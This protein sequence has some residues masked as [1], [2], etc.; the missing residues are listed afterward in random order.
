MKKFVALLVVFTL[1]FIPLIQ[2]TYASD[3]DVLEQLKNVNANTKIK[4]DER[5]NNIED[6]MSYEDF[7]DN[8]LSA[9]GIVAT[10]LKILTDLPGFF[11]TALTT[12]FCFLPSIPTIIYGIGE[13]FQISYFDSS[14][15]GYAG[16]LSGVVSSIY[17]GFRN[18]AMVIYV[19]LIAYL[20]IRMLLAS[21]GKQKAMYKTLIKY[22]FIGLLLLGA[23]HFIM[24]YVIWFSNIITN[25]FFNIAAPYF[26]HIT[27]GISNAVLYYLGLTLEGI[28]DSTQAD[29]N[30]IIGGG[31][32]GAAELT[33]Y[34]IT[35]PTG[36]IFGG[37][38]EGVVG[39]SSFVVALLPAIFKLIAALAY[40]GVLLAVA[41]TYLKRLFM[42]TL[43]IILYPFVSMSYVFDKIGDRKAQTLERWFREFATNVFI[44]PIHAIILTFLLFFMHVLDLQNIYIIGPLFGVIMLMLLFKGEEL[45]KNLFQ[46]SDGMGGVSFSKSGAGMLGTMAAVGGGIRAIGGLRQGISARNALDTFEKEKGLKFEERNGKIRKLTNNERLAKAQKG[47]YLTEY[48]RLRNE[49][50]KGRNEM[51]GFGGGMMTGAFSAGLGGSIKH[52]TAGF[53][54]G[55]AGVRAMATDISGIANVRDVNSLYKDID[56]ELN[57]IDN[58]EEYMSADRLE[59]ETD[60]PEGNAAFK[61]RTDKVKRIEKKLGVER[62][63]LKG[64]SREKL[65]K[66]L[67]DQKRVDLAVAKYGADSPLAKAEAASRELYQTQ[68]WT[69]VDASKLKY[70]QGEK[71]AYVYNE[72]TGQLQVIAGKGDAV[73]YAGGDF[74]GWI[75]W[76]KDDESRT[77]NLTELAHTYAK[78][79][80]DSVYKDIPK[81]SEEYTKME[82]RLFGQE[83][84]R[85]QT[86][87]GTIASGVKM[88]GVYE[89]ERDPKKIDYHSSE[90]SMSVAM[91]AIAQHRANADLEKI[92]SVLGTYGISTSTIQSVFD[93]YG[94]QANISNEDLLDLMIKNNTQD[95]SNLIAYVNAGT[96]GKI[97]AGNVADFSFIKDKLIS[98]NA[99]FSS[100]NEC[101]FDVTKNSVGEIQIVATSLDTAE[102]IRQVITLTDN[103]AQK[104]SNHFEVPANS[105]ELITTVGY[106]DVNGSFV[107][108]K[109]Y[110]E[111]TNVASAL[112]QEITDFRN[113]ENKTVVDAIDTNL[114][115][116]VKK[117]NGNN[118][119]YVEV[120]RHGKYQIVMDSKNNIIQTTEVAEDIGNK[121]HSVI[122]SYDDNGLRPIGDGRAKE[123][124]PYLARKITTQLTRE[125]LGD[126]QTD[127]EKIA[128]E[129]MKNWK[130]QERDFRRNNK[131]Y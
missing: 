71:N 1:C 74:S 54:L 40:L 49:G 64:V 110:F 122:Y 25:L 58:L 2:V 31:V 35:K 97:D 79:Q 129:M 32:G 80:M 19:I 72:E 12:L 107:S 125:K 23:G 18:F 38:T 89:F 69:K 52:A 106:N 92:S 94:S 123:L 41:W 9:G 128:N 109:G 126:V 17:S 67:A 15:V 91:K 113:I 121:A 76:S 43:L 65:D 87:E 5:N 16:S 45:I 51:F 61:A 6:G 103:E 112:I 56:D 73:K 82:N 48:S 119:E 11:V 81:D 115:N 88:P 28:Y 13:G 34:T 70:A 50:I 53:A 55:Q 118:M 120:V 14:P 124:N 104:Y 7:D 78:K 33:Y 68:D 3:M 98:E 75:S 21:V 46:I 62:G 4:E 26:E 101:K 86:L 111:R 99:Q 108:P 63:T 44:Q 105:G 27:G 130:R 93:N 8:T 20:A 24:A 90:V 85:L 60:T 66:Y 22:W 30:T 116:E 57:G 102:P 84:N 127:D 39:K 47:G 114:I 100:V 42:V 77:D 36:S 95:E 131:M 96:K 117:V 29:I 59:S 37:L 10:V 83:L